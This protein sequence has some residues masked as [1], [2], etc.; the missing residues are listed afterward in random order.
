[1]AAESVKIARSERPTASGAAPTPLEKPGLSVDASGFSD[2]PVRKDTLGFDLYTDGITAFLVDEKTTPPLTMSVEGE[3]GSGKSSLMLQ[4][5]EKLKAEIGKRGLRNYSVISFNAW[6]NDKA[7]SLWAAFAL[8]FL[9]QLKMSLPLH[10]RL[11][12]QAL[13]TWRRFDWDK[14]FWAAFKVVA[15]V[16]AVVG[17]ATWTLL[18]AKQGISNLAQGHLLGYKLNPVD[19]ATQAGIVGIVAALFA[20]LAGAVPYVRKFLG[21]PFTKELAKYA[22]SPDYKSHVN[23]I[24]TFQK[25]FARIVHSYVG[26]KGRVYIF[27]DDLDRCDVPGAVSVAY[28]LNM[29]MAA[30]GDNLVFVVGLD[31]DIVAAGIT[32]KYSRILPYLE[33]DRSS[34]SAKRDVSDYGHAF[35]EKFIQVPFKVPRATQS[36]VHGWLAKLGSSQAGGVVAPETGVSEGAV[37]FVVRIGPEN[38]EFRAIVEDFA[39]LL[40]FNPRK[41]KVFTNILRLR[42]VL[43]YEVGLFDDR[44]SWSQF[45]FFTAITTHWPKMISDLSRD[46]KLLGRLYR[47]EDGEAT[48]DLVAFWSRKPMLMAY[49]RGRGPDIS[50][51]D[52]EPLLV[53]LPR[54][55]KAQ[56]AEDPFTDFRP[57]PGDSAHAYGEMTQ[58]DDAEEHERDEPAATTAKK[59]RARKRGYSAAE[60]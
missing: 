14:G 43:A 30:C 34:T 11:I 10:R 51:L 1:M 47:H 26:E 15:F 36:A 31:R 44:I 42:M 3:W 8:S 22:A 58:A 32:A 9:E 4:V 18:K 45:A 20:A 19:P 46:P 54:R 24:G 13:L 7:E 41:I 55:Y 59:T 27:V 52:V 38:A 29:L 23:F 48:D 12:A 17:L 25:D 57:R 37:N 2:A 21:N 35:L 49:I 56:P 5:E 40:D 28:A 16:V 60:A 39:A 50:E 53:V 33:T 6:Q